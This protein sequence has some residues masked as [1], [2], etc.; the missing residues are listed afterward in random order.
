ME[1]IQ[2]CCC[3]ARLVSLGVGVGVTGCTWV[4]VRE[5]EPVPVCLSLCSW[6]VICLSPSLCLLPWPISCVSCR[7]WQMIEE[8]LQAKLVHAA[9]RFAK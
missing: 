2:C 4:G 8:V 5:G 1:Y 3:G 9:L 7:D 6:R